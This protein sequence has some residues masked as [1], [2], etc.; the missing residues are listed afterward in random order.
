MNSNANAGES[1]NFAMSRSYAGTGSARVSS[2]Y[3]EEVADGEGGGGG[4]TKA[5]SRSIEGSAHGGRRNSVS[6][7]EGSTR[8]GSAFYGGDGSAHGG[9]R[10][11]VSGKEGSTRRG[12]A[13]YGGDGSAH[14]GHHHRRG[15]G[16]VGESGLEEYKHL[17]RVPTGQ[18]RAV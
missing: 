15:S 3:L 1:V 13:F 10:N 11:S 6:G 17:H 4:A 2:G 7:R 5:R 8:R 12:S 16:L 9:R 14:G 18:G